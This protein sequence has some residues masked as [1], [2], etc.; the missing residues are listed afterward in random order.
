M[1]RIAAAAISFS[2]HLNRR[3]QY[4]H[5]ICSIAALDNKDQAQY[6][7]AYVRGWGSVRPVLTLRLTTSCHSDIDL[8][9]NY[10]TLRDYTRTIG[11]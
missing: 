1:L 4:S 3:M 7:G 6:S 10:F 8:T 2:L 9:L 5:D 11:Y